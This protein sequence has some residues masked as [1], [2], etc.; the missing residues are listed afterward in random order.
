MLIPHPVDGRAAACPECHKVSGGSLPLSYYWLKNSTNVLANGSRISGAQ[1]ATLTIS[2]IT[3]ADA[4]NYAI[5][6]KNSAGTLTNPA[7]AVQVV[8]LPIVKITNPA[9]NALIKSTNGTVTIRGT[10]TNNVS[11]ASVHWQVN[12]NGWRLATAVTGWNVWAANVTLSPDRKWIVFR[13]NM[14]GPVHVYAV[15]IAKSGTANAAP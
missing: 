11:V 10:A 3:S 14:L 2:N 7:V 12:S 9:Q 13:S 6:V 5:V 4:G 8:N 1:T 15:E